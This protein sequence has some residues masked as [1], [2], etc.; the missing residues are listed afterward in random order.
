MPSYYKDGDWY[1]VDPARS[2]ARFHLRAMGVPVFRG[3]LPLSA[4][5]LVIDADGGIRT[6]NLQMD[7][8]GVTFEAAVDQRITRGLFGSASHPLIEFET[9]WARAVGP[10]HH[11]LDG[12]LRLHGQVHPFTLRADRGAWEGAA[13][14]ARWYRGLVSGELDRKAWE[15]RSHT[16]AD[17]ALLLLGHE[18][19]FEVALCARPRPAPD[20]AIG[21]PPR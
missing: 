11:E 18:V 21:Q 17:G 8:A 3:L 5:E 15:L 20:P 1:T 16:L 19:L 12:V 14:D 13:V 10:T 2:E 9:Q 7:A 4:G 6:A